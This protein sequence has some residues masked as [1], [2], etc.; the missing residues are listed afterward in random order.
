MFEPNDLVWVKSD[1]YQYVGQVMSRRTPE[2]T[3]MVRRAPNHPGTLEE[4]SEKVLE[5][6]GHYRKRWIHY[7]RV[8][9]DWSH[10]FPVDMLRRDLACP[11]NFSLGGEYGNTVIRQ[12]EPGDDLLVATCTSTKNV[13]AWTK[14]RWESFG[15]SIRPLVVERI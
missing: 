9:P 8:A 10:H 1:G 3:Y 13:P 6:I 2:G 11:V 5:A 4:M 12:C 15:W 7:A 14:E